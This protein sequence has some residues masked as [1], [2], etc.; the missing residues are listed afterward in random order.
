[1][2]HKISMNRV[3]TLKYSLEFWEFILLAAL[4]SLLMCVFSFVVVKNI[5]VGNIFVLLSIPAHLNWTFKLHSIVFVKKERLYDI[6]Q[7][8]SD[9]QKYIRMSTV[10]PT[11]IH[12]TYITGHYKPSVRIIDLVSHTTYVVCVNLIHKWRDLQFKV[13]SERQIFLRE[14][15]HGNFIYSQEFVPEICWEKIAAEK[16]FVF[17]FD[18][19]PVART[20]A[21]RLISQHITY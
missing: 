5:S 3:L 11:Y 15:F 14:T 12:N 21:F 6:C 13:H 10:L 4:P 2:K 1:M 9:I 20:L 18:V 8:G 19:W 7:A 16:L 17:C